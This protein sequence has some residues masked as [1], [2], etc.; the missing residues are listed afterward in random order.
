VTTGLDSFSAYSVINT[1]KE[2][3]GHCHQPQKSLE[4]RIVVT[5]IHQ[6]T[7]DIFH[8]FTNII[9]M[10]AGRIIFQGTVEEAER[11]F[12]SMDMLCPPCYN[13]AEFYI[14]VISDPRK[15]SE[16]I[17]FVSSKLEDGDAKTFTPSSS[18]LESNENVKELQK[19]LPWLQQCCIISQRTTLNFV[20][21]PNHYLIELF[22]LIVSI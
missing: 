11:L 21:A 1:L 14:N 3:A 22:I 20:R 9:L 17:K 10:S 16:I 5:T 15:S 12:S 19:S 18:S 13:P 2:L 8:L 4:S 7:S 6:P